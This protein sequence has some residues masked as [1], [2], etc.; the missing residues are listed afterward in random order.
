MTHTSRIVTAI[1]AVLFFALSGNAQECRRDSVKIWFRQ[2]K[3]DLV[4]GLHGN[5]ENLD[6]AT[7][8]LERIVSNP[9]MYRLKSVHFVGAASPEGSIRFNRWLSE[10]RAATLI[11]YLDKY[12]SFPDSLVTVDCLGR[13]WQ[14]LKQ[15]VLADPQVP[16][17][18]RV[19]S[20][21]DSKPEP[22][23]E[24]KATKA[25][26]YLYWNHFPELRASSLVLE[27]QCFPVLLPAGL[28]SVADYAEVNQITPP[29]RQIRPLQHLWVDVR[30]NLLYDALAAP[31]LGFDVYLG[32]GFSLGANWKYAWFKNDRRHFYWRDYGGDINFKYWFGEL[33]QQRPLQGHHLGLY[34]QAFTYDFEFGGKGVMG[35]HPGGN[36]LD[37]FNTIV[38]AEYGYSLP[39][40]DKWN[41]DFSIGAGYMNGLFREYHPEDECYVWDATK[42]QQYF[43]LTKLEISLVRVFDFHYLEKGG[44]RQ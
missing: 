8:R 13:D 18:D 23:A 37:E 1:V 14:G 6:S 28:S 32:S 10:Q 25:Y 21:I 36:L 35:G 17:R 43:G 22:L 9:F 42:K 11:G 3:I 5:K 15:R 39:L 4:P 30:S 2:S 20:L 34:A 41:L 31:N 29:Y 33:A 27:Y 44:K 24:L 19:L 40:N 26:P 7:V 38:A 12:V 16:Q